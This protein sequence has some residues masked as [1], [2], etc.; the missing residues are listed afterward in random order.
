MGREDDA[1]DVEKEL[2]VCVEEGT[3]REEADA[4]ALIHFQGAA[5]RCAGGGCADGG[6]CCG[7]RG[8]CGVMGDW[9]LF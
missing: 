9:R 5:W 8:L 6:C 1:I 3:P 7:V 2:L 4:L